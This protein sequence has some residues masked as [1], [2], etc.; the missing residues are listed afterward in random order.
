MPEQLGE[1]IGADSR[2]LEVEC[3]QLYCAPPFGSFVR[4]ECIGS[5]FAQFAVVTRVA[6]GPF[7]GSRIIQAHR[8][9]PGELEQKK[10]HLTTLLRTLFTAQIVGYGKDGAHVNGTPPLPPRLHCY[11]YPATPEE[12]K[13]MTA[14]PAFLRS[15]V[16]AQEVSLEDLLVS[17]IES[18]RAAWGHDA[19]L[20][21]WGKYLAR[22]LH[23][24]Y[25][26]LEGVLQR[27]TPAPAPIGALAA[28]PPAAAPA[29]RVPAH[30]LY[31][32]PIRIAGPGTGG[33]GAPGNGAHGNG[34]GGTGS[35]RKGRLGP[36][37]D[38]FAED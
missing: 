3:H 34:A 14:S 21:S 33:N 15:L 27:L 35:P 30:P 8:L 28:A 37:D 26:T 31:E 19:P 23:R 36:N 29:A 6:T 24:D 16:V 12:V 9:P 25:V 4:A 13:A 18:A 20:V 11:V 5:G 17:A 2:V 10:P 32:E 7:D 22:L 38:P 1:T